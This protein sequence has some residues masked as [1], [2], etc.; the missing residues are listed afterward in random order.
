LGIQND[1]GNQM[2]DEN[3]KNHTNVEWEDQK[4]CENIYLNFLNWVFVGKHI[5]IS[6]INI[7]CSAIS[8]FICA[9]IPQF[10]FAQTNLVKNIRKGFMTSNPKK[11]KYPTI[12]NPDVLIDYYYKNKGD[13]LPIDQQYQFLQTKIAI[14]LGYLHMLRPQEAWSCETTDKSELQLEFNKGLWLRTIVKNNKTSMSDIWIPNIDL[15]ISQKV[16]DN[17]TE[18][19]DIDTQTSNPLNVFYAIHLLKT[20]IILPNVKKTVC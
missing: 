17:N 6:S 11:P 16:E 10:N 1:W 7:T 15:M 8:K 14:L 18:Q 20:M 3:Y 19:T 2:V 5:P 9:F 4:E 13:N 12:W